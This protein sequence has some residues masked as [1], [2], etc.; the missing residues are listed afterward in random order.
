MFFEANGFQL[1]SD[2]PRHGAITAAAAAAASKRRADALFVVVTMRPSSVQPRTK[3]SVVAFSDGNDL[4]VAIVRGGTATGSQGSVAPFQCSGELTRVGARAVLGVR[5]QRHAIET[6]LGMH[7]GEDLDRSNGVSSMSAVAGEE[8]VSKP[9]VLPNHHLGG[10]GGALCVVA[11]AS[12]FTHGPI[13]IVIVEEDVFLKVLVAL[14][15]SP[16]QSMVRLV[17]SREHLV[18]IGR[19]VAQI[20]VP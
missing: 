15:A 13:G 11:A 8:S 20:A 3:H 9:E 18:W 5:H 12:G 14:C 17:I 4:T 10:G 19:G 1:L 7:L 6:L 2:A 16:Y